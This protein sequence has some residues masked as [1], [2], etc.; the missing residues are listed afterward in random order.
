MRH[1]CRLIDLIQMMQFDRLI[2][3]Q[4]VNQFRSDYI[5]AIWNEDSIQTFYNP[6]QMISLISKARRYKWLILELKLQ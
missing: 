5:I 2:M 6:I 4:T 1:N 3:S